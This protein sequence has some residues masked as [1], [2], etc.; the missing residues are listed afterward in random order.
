[1]KLFDYL[2][3]IIGILKSN[4]IF[5]FMVIVFCYLLKVTIKLFN[6]TCELPLLACNVLENAINE[7]SLH[8]FLHNEREV[9]LIFCLLYFLLMMMFTLWLKYLKTHI[10]WKDCILFRIFLD[11][12]WKPNNPRN[13]SFHNCHYFHSCHQILSK[14]VTPNLFLL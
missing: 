1:M 2:I 10:I 5:V 14:F 7:Y 3:G 4:Y 9:Q 12:P 8:F 11:L 13:L 6:V